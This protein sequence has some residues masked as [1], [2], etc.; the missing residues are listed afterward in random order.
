MKNRKIILLVIL[1]LAL[2]APVAWAQEL[3][4]SD[5]P[6]VLPSPTSVPAEYALPYPG[7][8]PDSPFYF[9]KVARDR[10]MG[11][12]TSGSLRKAELDLL[13]ADKRVEASRILFSK[14]RADLG[15]STFSKALN[16]L[17]DAIKE[18]R[19]AKKEGMPTEDIIKRMN[20]ATLKYK[21]VVRDIKQKSKINKDKIRNEEARFEKL[22]KEVEQLVP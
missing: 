11:F 16:Y 18:V 7:L 17:G 22:S 6:M 3:V 2:S 8:L 10:V 4:I 12:L 19:E 14:K 15:E 21:E 5:T 1:F 20:A 9:F 13:Q